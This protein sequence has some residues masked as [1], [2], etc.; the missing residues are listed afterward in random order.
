MIKILT[1]PLALH[2]S[3]LKFD[4]GNVLCKTICTLAPHSFST[5]SF[6]NCAT[7]HS[8]EEHAQ[9]MNLPGCQYSYLIW[10][11]LPNKASDWHQAPFPSTDLGSRAE[12][13]L[14]YSIS[15]KAFQGLVASTIISALAECQALSRHG[16]FSTVCR[17]ETSPKS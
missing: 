2:L 14:K 6:D 8:N 5:I 13:N 15:L 7:N 17:P 3:S 10:L 1:S 4:E 9:S 12:R 16:Y 11:R